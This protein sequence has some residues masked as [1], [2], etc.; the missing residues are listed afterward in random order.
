MASD[1][2]QDSEWR[3]Q[4]EIFG[5]SIMIRG[6]NWGGLLRLIYCLSGSTLCLV[7]EFIVVVGKIDHQSTSVSILHRGRHRPDVYSAVSPMF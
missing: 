1:Q 5:D 4:K 7:S 3:Q 2:N 6:P